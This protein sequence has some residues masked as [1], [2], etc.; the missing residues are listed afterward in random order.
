M[1]PY[2]FVRIEDADHPRS[3]AH[4]AGHVRHVSL[5]YYEA[6]AVFWR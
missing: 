6:S 2:V 4:G 5:F 1:L 3:E